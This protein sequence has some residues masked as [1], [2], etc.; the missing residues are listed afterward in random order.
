[1]IE[2]NAKVGKPP[3]YLKNLLINRV[4]DFVY[5]S[6]SLWRDDLERDKTVEAEELLNEQFCTFLNAEA[7]GEEAFLFHHEQHQ[8]SR[9][10]V[11]MA[12]KPTKQLISAGTYHSKYEVITTFEAKRLPAPSSSRKREYVTGEDKASGGIQ[13]YKLRLHGADQNV[14]GMIGYVQRDSFLHFHNTINGYIDE[15]TTTSS[16]L[17]WSADEKLS[18]LE[19]DVDKRTARIKSEHLRTNDSIITLH[20]LWVDMQEN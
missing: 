17:A 13:R 14:A 1:M 6:L 18:K 15:L 7:A 8:A 2:L 5:S 19:S 9:R 16:D 3:S 12:A 10:R 20:H 4:I 11:D